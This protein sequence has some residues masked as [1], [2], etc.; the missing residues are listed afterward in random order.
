MVEVV[1]KYDVNNCTDCPFRD[2]WR[3][4]GEC[5]A[6]C[7]HKDHGQGA[8]GCILWGCQEE[9]EAVPVWCPLGLGE[10]NRR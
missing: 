7:T 2:D 9:F 10:R 4:H 5:W 3:G 8:Y 6:E 1:F